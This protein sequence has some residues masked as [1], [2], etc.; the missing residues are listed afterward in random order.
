MPFQSTADIPANLRDRIPSGEADRFISV[1]NDLW[2]TL[3]DKFQSEDALESEVIQRALGVVG[4]EMAED[5][6]FYV[7]AFKH[8][9]YIRHSL[10]DIRVNQEF[11]EEM[12]AGFEKLTEYGYY[13]PVLRAH[14]P[15]KDLN[16]VSVDDNKGPRPVEDGFVFGRIFDVVDSRSDRGQQLRESDT[17]TP[18]TEGI[19]FG[20][21][22][23]SPVRRAHD[24]GLIDSWS[25][26]LY[27]NQPA[28]HPEMGETLTLAPRHN[29]FVS[30]PHQ[31]NI[32]GTSPHYDLTED[33]QERAGLHELDE[34]SRPFVDASGK[35]FTTQPWTKAEDTH[36]GEPQTRSLNEEQTMSDEDDR[37]EKLSSEVEALKSSVSELV[38]ALSG[39]DEDEEDVDDPDP[40]LQELR[41]ENQRLRRERLKDK[42]TSAGVEDED[43]VER[44]VELAEDNKAEDLIDELVGQ[45]GDLEDDGPEFGESGK[46]GDPPDP[47]DDQQKAQEKYRELHED[48]DVD[49]PLEALSSDFD[50]D[51][52]NKLDPISAQ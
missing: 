13:P 9:T 1:F 17:P 25:P 35:P 11:V 42:I 23:P 2:A 18:D 4:Q 37:Y 52:I 29:A 16:E 24:V 27:E 40:E 45:V 33:C 22:V 10:G 51:T 7:T 50:M 26:G 49:R 19:W 31:K 6:R 8:G 14:K 34:G 43:E 39:D 28:P 47:E 36:S 12:T 3:K 46:T 30:V 38:E 21:E 15:D 20:Q 48:P 32:G 41:E 5:D 44:L